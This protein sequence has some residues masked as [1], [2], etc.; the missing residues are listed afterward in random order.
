MRRTRFRVI[1]TFCA[2]TFVALVIGAPVAVADK[3]EP[4]PAEEFT[5]DRA[6]CG[7]PVSVEILRNKE[8]AIT[9][10][11]GMTIV[12]GALRLRLT[13]VDDPTHS[14][15]L[16]V[17]GPGFFDESGLIAT[18]PWLFFFSP[19]EFGPGSPGILALFVGRSQVNE[20]GLQLLAGRQVDLCP[21]LASG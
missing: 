11:N 8:K 7:F 15:V 9:V 16:N 6:I 12:N 5:I 18:G 17:P 20:N 10:S 19:G 21:Q 4:T 14:I 2:V 13:N 3:P 1:T